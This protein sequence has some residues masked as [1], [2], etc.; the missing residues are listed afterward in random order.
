MERIFED[1][2]FAILDDIG[3]KEDAV[4][5]ELIAPLLRGLGY[6]PTGD[7]RVERSKNLVHLFVMIGT[8]KRR[9]DIVPDY[10]LSHKGQPLL[11]LDAKNPREDILKSRHAEQAYSY[12]IHPEVRCGHY[13]LC[14][15]RQ[16]VVYETAKIEPI[17]VV[18]MEALTWSE[19]RQYLGVLYL[20]KPLLRTFLPDL[21]IHFQRLGQLP[22]ARI[23]FDPAA[24]GGL[25]RLEDGIWCAS[26]GLRLDEQDFMATFEFKQ[27]VLETILG[28]IPSEFRS[29]AERALGRSPFSIS[30]DRLIKL[31]CVTRL[32]EMTAGEHETFVPFEILS[33]QRAEFRDDEWVDVPIG[34][35]DYVLSLAKLIGKRGEDV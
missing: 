13:A 4:R 21:G 5:E 33:V 16:L 9:I 19:A 25:S 29:Q 32:G 26:A 18:E 31:K 28:A 1:F 10:T 23:A 15:G 6:G 27:D 30:I 17:L 22:G 7:A 12:A 20:Q 14:N 34:L 8:T 2:D 11:I 3:F 24:V 35:P